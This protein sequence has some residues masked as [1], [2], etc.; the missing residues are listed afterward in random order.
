MIE[1]SSN[2]VAVVVPMYKRELD[3]NEQVS[4]RH[5]TRYLAKFD[6]FLVTPESLRVELEGFGIKRFRDEFFH[7]TA[8]YSALL[9]SREFYEAFRHYEYMLVYQL[10]SLVFSDKLLDWCAKDFDYIGAPWFSEAGA[11]FVEESGVG[12]GGL[13]LRRIASFL[14][15][16]ERPGADEEMEKYRDALDAALP[17]YRQL[18]RLPYKVR[19]RLSL[20]VARGQDI[21]NERGQVPAGER[22]NEDCFWSFKARDYYPE[23]KIAPVREALS[24]AFE[25][26]P[27][28]CFELNGK[29]LPFGCHAWSK[30]DREFWEPFLLK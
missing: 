22:L 18:L 29:R 23:F 25:M 4:Y 7:S 10:D 27:R 8:T 19:K 5:L 12:N 9:I 14:K 16:L 26:A 24:F 17:W 3:D 6:K 30:Y 20:S 11:D 1:E 21:L 15:V 13:S 2:T 28:R